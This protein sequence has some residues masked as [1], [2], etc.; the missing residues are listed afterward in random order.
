MQRKYQLWMAD[1]RDE[2]GVRHRKGFNTKRKAERFK[3]K[4]DN[5]ANQTKKAPRSA[6]SGRSSKRGHALRPK[7]TTRK[8]LRRR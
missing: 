3:T 5:A 6:Q 4:M 7:A 8:S 2:N 1:W